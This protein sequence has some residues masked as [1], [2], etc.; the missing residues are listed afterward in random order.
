MKGLSRRQTNA[1]V[2]Q[3]I[4]LAGGFHAILVPHICMYSHELG[5]RVQPLMMQHYY[6]SQENLWNQ[7]GALYQFSREGWLFLGCFQ[8]QQP[9]ELA[10]LLAGVKLC[11]CV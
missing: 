11:S 6:H 3:W 9:L 1:S 5:A 10:D 7:Q 2:F 8:K 4:L